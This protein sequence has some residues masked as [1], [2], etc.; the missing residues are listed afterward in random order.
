MSVRLVLITVMAFAVLLPVGVTRA[1]EPLSIE[2]LVSHCRHFPED[3]DGKDGIFCVRYIQ[4]FI[5]GAVATDDRVTR[6]VVAEYE[7]DETFTERAIRIRGKRFSQF[8]TY[9]AEFCL[10]EPIS[11]KEI[12]EKIVRHLR[13]REVAGQQLLARGVVYDVLRSEYPCEQD[14]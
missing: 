3:P 10:G 6:N 9:Y 2:E 7:R 5:D 12:V 13:N 11:L 14:D 8:S 1:V 4:G